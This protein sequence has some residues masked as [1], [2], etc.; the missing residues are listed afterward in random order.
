[1]SD[2]G[3]SVSEKTLKTI[4][5][6]VHKIYTQAAKELKAKLSDF[7]RK[8]RAKAEEMLAKVEKGL[9]TEQDY[10][11]WL[12][13]QLFTQKQW[14][15]KIDQCSKIMLNANK[16]AMLIVNG[17]KMEVFSENYD[18]S[19]YRLEKIAGSLNFSIYNTESLAR[20]IKK[21]PTIL[22][23]YKP[24]Q[25]KDYVW[26]YNKVKNS[27][28]QGIIQGESVDQITDRLITNLCSQNESKMRMFAR[29][30]IT[31]AQNAGRIEQ[32][33]DAEGMGI[34][35]KKR[36]LAT[37]DDR[38]R[39]THARL[40]GDTIPVDERFSNGLEYPGDPHGDPGEV[41][42]CRCTLIQIYDG[43]ERKSVR[44][45]YDEPDESGRRSS[46][47]VEDMTYTEWK[48]WKEKGGRVH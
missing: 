8:H 42:N 24:D 46:Y 31:G 10:K 47:L 26:N 21:D 4:E 17:G 35:V 40:D 16:Q 43:I 29:T 14:E 48:E 2:Y 37:L 34:K 15:N 27:V 38:T 45:A 12:V 25:K 32:M 23:V 30:S 18:Y 28:T 9:I 7:T 11:S 22:P 33:H 5:R 36:W 39:D 1:M 19:A 44:R 3:E 20:L 6:Q 41:Y 13:G